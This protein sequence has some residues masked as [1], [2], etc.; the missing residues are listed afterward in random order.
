MSLMKARNLVIYSDD[1]EDLKRLA[2]DYRFIGRDVMIE[3]GKLTVFA[4][5]R[6]LKTRKQRLKDDK[7]KSNRT[8]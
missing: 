2:D 6:K 4:I 3:D 7:K 1:Q 8:R 5:H